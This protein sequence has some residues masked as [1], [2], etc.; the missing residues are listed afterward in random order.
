MRS[1]HIFGNSDVELC[2]E[3]GKIDTLKI[4]QNWLLQKKTFL[5]LDLHIWNNIS[6]IREAKVSK[7]NFL[8]TLSESKSIFAIELNAT[9]SCFVKN[10][11]F[12]L[13][14]PIYS[15]LP[16]IKYV[17]LVQEVPYNDLVRIQHMVIPCRVLDTKLIPWIQVI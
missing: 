16:A 2:E 9:V 10:V 6:Q 4:A 5:S 7:F 17:F 15:R 14:H 8:H 12:L 3:V 11:A 1:V 13:R